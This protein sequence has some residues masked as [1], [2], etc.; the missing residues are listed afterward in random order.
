MENKII[1]K[2]IK[3]L[4]D[5]IGVSKTAVRNKLN[6]EIK[7]KFA[8]TNGNTLY[9]SPKGEGI[10]KAMFLTQI[11]NQSQTVFDNHS[12]TK[13]QTVCKVSDFTQMS[14]II[15]VLEDNTKLLQEQL[16]QKDN[17][18]QNLQDENKRL[19]SALENTTLSLQASQTLHAKSLQLVSSNDAEEPQKEVKKKKGL[20]GILKK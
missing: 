4:A 8:T 19:I 12:Q 18:I 6:D 17:Q 10:I 20:F 3:Q 9:I 1:G 14:S 13:T 11:A 15:K 2:T 5:E 7:T 16:K